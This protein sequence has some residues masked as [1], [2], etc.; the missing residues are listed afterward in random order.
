MK[1]ADS[2]DRPKVSIGLPVY[3]GENFLEQAIQSII[4]QT[5]SDF[6]LII[7]DNASTDRTPEIYRA[8]AKRDPR[9]RY[10]RNDTNIGAAPNY[11][12][13]FVA[14]RGRFFKWAAHDD[15][16]LPDFLQ[17]C[18][19]ALEADPGAVLAMPRAATIDERGNMIRECEWRR[20]FS[21]ATAEGRFREAL[22]PWET[23]PIWGLI[24]IEVLRRTALLGSYPGHD[25]PL[26]A[27]LALHGR[28][29]EVQ[30]VLF[31]QR[32]HSGQ[33]VQVY[34]FRDPHQ[35]VVWYDP[36]KR[37]KLIFPFWREFTEYFV[38]ICRAPLSAGER[39]RCWRELLPDTPIS[40]GPSEGPGMGIWARADARPADSDTAPTR[41]QHA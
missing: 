41:R 2:S 36:K 13:V 12:K 29:N 1:M 5:F 19:Q 26:L 7:S 24:R 28:F 23:H 11:T 4:D 38:A 39:L 40:W 30:E 31:L 32:E 33:S 6:E 17:R 8:W 16:C 10:L 9:V 35:A 14:A 18:V 15:I 21:A 22:H 34:D 25:R 37:G 20:A 3:N 27:E